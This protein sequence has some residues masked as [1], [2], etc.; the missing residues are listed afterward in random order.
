VL[1]SAEARQRLASELYQ[2]FL[3]RAATPVEQQ[4]VVSVLQN[5][6]TDEGVAATLVGSPEYLA[7]VP[8]SFASA[9]I[10]W[11]D[12]NASGG[13]VVGGSVVGSHTYAEEGFYPVTVV[14]H[15][16]DGTL[17]LA[18][19]AVVGDAPL[20]ASGSSFAVVKKSTFTHTVAT[21]TDANPGGTAA[22][23]SASIDWGDGRTSAGVVSALAGGGFAVGGSHRYDF[24]GSYR[25]TVR[26]ADAGGSTAAAFST[27]SVLAKP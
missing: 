18:G 24:K 21:F 5:G 8:P 2:R 26:I 17:T 3:H 13:A 23:F 15:D 6:G 4:T 11:G 16:L 10:D 1:T 14:V 7:N 9:T 27:V 20:S 19:S 12:G 25:I 22:E